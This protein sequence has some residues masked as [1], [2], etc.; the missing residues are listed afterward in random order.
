MFAPA[1]NEEELN[2]ISNDNIINIDN[3]TSED[4]RIVTDETVTTAQQEL[5]KLTSAYKQIALKYQII[6]LHQYN[7]LHLKHKYN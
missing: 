3:E 6:H 2:E 1:Q 4:E 5:N 7:I